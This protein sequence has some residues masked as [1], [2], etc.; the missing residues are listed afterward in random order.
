MRPKS[1][2]HQAIDGS[3]L[4]AGYELRITRRCGA[5]D[6]DCAELDPFT[7]RASHEIVRAFINRRQEKPDN[8]RQVSPLSTGK[9]VY[10]LAY[11]DRHRGA[12]WHDEAH[13]VVW[14][15]AYAQHEFK[16]EGD[17]FP[18]FKALDASGRLLPTTEDYQGLFHARADRLAHAVP[19]DCLDLLTEARATSGAEIN[20]TI[21]SQVHLSCCVETSSELEEITIAIRYQ[22]LTTESLPIILASF[23][24]DASPSELE[25]AGN[26][27]GRD[28]SSDEIAYRWIREAG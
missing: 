17:A 24:P 14:L 7:H 12:T 25:Q 8:T 27:A 1:L 22:G 23:F 15:L 9:P 16:R 11:G 21:A 6:L 3:Y 4:C 5:E 19:A 26:I 28:L 18:Y 20:G 13:D 10:R 2:L